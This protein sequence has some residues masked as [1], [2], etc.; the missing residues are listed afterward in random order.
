V[1]L[2]VNRATPTI[3]WVTP[4]AITYGT[5]LSAAQLNASSILSGSFLYTPA[6][7]TVLAAGTQTLSVI[8]TPAN[9]TDYSTAA[10]TVQLTVNKAAQTIAFTQPTSPVTYSGTP[11]TL[12]LSADSTSGLEANFSVASG[13]ATVSGSTLKITGVGTV[14][15][16]ANQAGSANYLAAPQVTR[17]I[18]VER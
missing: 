11:I 5:A 10:K 15:V 17:S 7:G 18:T 9:T 14:V 2:T 13:P 1:Q 8:F 3:R 4:K 6:V 16:A 12:T